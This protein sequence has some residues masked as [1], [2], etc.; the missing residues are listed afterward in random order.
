[1]VEDC[2]GFFLKLVLPQKAVQIKLV[3]RIKAI[4][5]SNRE[6]ELMEKS[7]AAIV[8]CVGG[9]TVLSRDESDDNFGKRWELYD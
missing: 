2:N 3:S 6:W 7:T 8:D 4:V 1:M 9:K 5:F